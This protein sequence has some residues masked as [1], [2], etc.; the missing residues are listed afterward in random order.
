M[1]LGAGEAEEQTILFWELGTCKGN[2]AQEIEPVTDR[3]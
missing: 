1:G 3:K 2:K